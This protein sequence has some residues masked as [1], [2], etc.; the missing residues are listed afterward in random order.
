MPYDRREPFDSYDEAFTN[1]HEYHKFLLDYGFKID[2]HSIGKRMKYNPSFKTYM[3]NPDAPITADYD[4]N[5]GYMPTFD[6]HCE[7]DV[8]NSLMGVADDAKY[9]QRRTIEMTDELHKRDGNEKAFKEF[10]AANKGIK[11]Q[12]EEFK[13]L[14]KLGGLKDG[15]L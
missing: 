4:H 14:C 11:E 9:F 13:L 5:V 6:L 10:L 2:H 7:G 1:M 8:V 3:L 12:Y 15:I